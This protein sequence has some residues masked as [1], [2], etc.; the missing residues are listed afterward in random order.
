MKR[1]HRER[2][3]VSNIEEVDK[4]LKNQE[5]LPFQSFQTNSNNSVRFFYELHISS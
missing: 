4:N 3:N 1:F 2:F 5:Q